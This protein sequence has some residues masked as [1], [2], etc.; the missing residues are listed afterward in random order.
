MKKKIIIFSIIIVTSFINLLYFNGFTKEESK[1]EESSQKKMVIERSLSMMLEKETGSGEY[2]LVTRSD[3]PT[4]GYVF[5]ETLSKCENGGE[6]A[7][8]DENKLVMMFGVISDKCYA[9]FDKYNSIVINSSSI[10]TS[11]T[12]IVISLNATSGDGAIAKYYYSIDGGESYVDTTVNAYTF[13]NLEIGVYDV[14]VYALDSNG[15]KSST[16]SKTIKIEVILFTDYIVSLYGGTQGNNN[17]YYHD[18]SLAN[19]ISDYSY[20]Y[21][22][23]STSVNNYV[24]IS[25]ETI[26]TDANLYRIIGIIDGK[27][28]LIKATSLGK[29][30]WNSVGSTT[31]SSS[32]LNTYLNGEFLTSLGDF[33]DN[34]AT[35]TW[36]VGGNI[37]DAIINSAPS[38]AYTREI[39]SPLNSD[40]VSNKI[41]L[42]YVSDYGFAAT[43]SSWNANL[44]SYYNVASNDW[45]FLGVLEWTITRATDVSTNVLSVSSV[46]SVSTNMTNISTSEVVRPV[47][48]LASTVGY[49]SGLGTSSIPFRL[50]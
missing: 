49:S 19:G 46:G 43:I 9:Y 35:T 29:Y 41:G 16:I 5:N 39:T 3:W 50:S 8:D 15:Y 32:S 36:K 24:C 44:S 33:A 40:T 26:C 37:R 30:A 42:M 11:G 38:L 17:I 4:D 23:A 20:R 34:I 1:L 28:K 27:V 31:W 25:N 45:L 14:K 21:A 22:G 12:S 18:G 47:F 10:T 48:F 2:E 6:L 7:W 13:S